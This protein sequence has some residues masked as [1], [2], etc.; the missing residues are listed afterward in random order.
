MRYPRQVVELSNQMV[1]QV[2]TVCALIRKFLTL[3]HLLLLLYVIAVSNSLCLLQLSVG[4]HHCLALTAEGSVYGWGGNSNQEITIATAQTFVPTLIP[5]LSRQG[6][7]SLI[8][9]I[10]FVSI[11]DIRKKKKNYIDYSDVEF[12]FV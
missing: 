4:K 1:T 9:G 11:F 7:N 10:Y 6:V 8:C 5:E 2:Y 3:I 12:C